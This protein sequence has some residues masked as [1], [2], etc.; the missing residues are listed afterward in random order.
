MPVLP[1]LRPSA[2]ALV[3]G[4]V[5]AGC[6]HTEGTRVEREEARL[7]TLLEGRVAGEP[8]SCIAVFNIDRLRI[9]DRTAVTYETGDTIW[10]ARPTD[11]RSL[12][13]RD[14]VVVRR[15]GSQLCKQDVIR[16]VDR[17]SGITTGVVFLDDF[18]PYRRP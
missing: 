7:A 16:T 15:T 4:A 14:I 18:V 12:D 8:E 17:T 3:L 1:A 2:A 11:P 6:A 9:Y 13:T 10:V 5:L